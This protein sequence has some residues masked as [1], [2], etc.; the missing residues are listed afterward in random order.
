MCMDLDVDDNKNDLGARKRV[1]V[2]MHINIH[3][4]RRAMSVDSYLRA[5]ALLHHVRVATIQRHKSVGCDLLR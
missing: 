4:A 3:N 2:N 1:V 5:T